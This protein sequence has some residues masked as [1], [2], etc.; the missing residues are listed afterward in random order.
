MTEN[1][2]HRVPR[3]EVDAV[4]ARFKFDPY[5]KGKGG[6]DE[7][8]L[9]RL[10]RELHD[11]IERSLPA[12]QPG[13]EIE[14]GWDRLTAEE[15]EYSS[16]F[17]YLQHESLFLPLMREGW[18]IRRIH[19]EMVAMLRD[20]IALDPE[21]LSEYD[22]VVPSEEVAKIEEGAASAADLASAELERLDR[23]RVDGHMLRYGI[24]IGLA[25]A[26]EGKTEHGDL[27]KLARQLADEAGANDPLERPAYR[28]DARSKEFIR[29]MRAQLDAKENP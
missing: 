13:A 2:Y 25:M 20:L 1:A 26:L 27:A 6:D 4:L 18:G 5:A 29:E 10:V 7:F 11:D 24:Y 16:K 9:N 8:Y 14:C 12:L 19:R 22:V 28:M 15:R 23:T 21:R 17:F 3:D